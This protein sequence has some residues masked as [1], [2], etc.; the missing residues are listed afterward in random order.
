ML[1]DVRADVFRSMRRISSE[2]KPDSAVGG[3]VGIEKGYEGLPH[4][5]LAILAHLT[6]AFSGWFA[7]DF[8]AHWA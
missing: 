6:G 5:R 8:F 1:R 2:K 4:C 3:Q 7:A